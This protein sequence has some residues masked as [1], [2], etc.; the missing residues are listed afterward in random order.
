[1][2]FSFVVFLVGSISEHPAK[3][4]ALVG[5]SIGPHTQ[6]RDFRAEGLKIRENFRGA[7]EKGERR[8]SKDG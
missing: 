2:Q 6:Q 5:A 4:L 1:M 7:R 3:S 8:T